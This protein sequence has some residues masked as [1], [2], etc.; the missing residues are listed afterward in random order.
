ML[1][2]TKIAASAPMDAACDQ[3]GKRL[4][5]EVSSCQCEHMC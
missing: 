3:L 5:T 1:E 4:M 2:G